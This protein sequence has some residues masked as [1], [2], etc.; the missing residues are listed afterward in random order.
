M[1]MKLTAFEQR[2]SDRLPSSW[3]AALVLVATL[4]A[5]S[6][7]AQPA[8]QFYAGKQ[9]K[10]IIGTSAGGG[11]DTNARLLARY[12][13][14]HIPG[15]PT[16]VPQNMPGAGGIRASSFLYSSAPQDG[17][18][19]G[20]VDSSNVVGPLFEK[21][22]EQFDPAK[23]K[24]VGSIG[25]E[26]SLCVSWHETPIK[27]TR[28]FLEKEF[29]VGGSGAGGQLEIYPKV[30]NAIIGTRMKIISGYAGGNDVVL[31]MERGEVQGRCGWSYSGIMSTRPTW[32][33]E[34]KLNF[35]IQLGGKAAELPEVPVVTDLVTSQEHKD[36]LNVI[37]A[38]RQV[39]RG[40]FAPPGISEAQLEVLR[41]A[42]MDTMRDPNFLA[43]AEKM[44][45]TPA[46]TTGAEVQAIVERL[47]Q[48]SPKVIDTAAK[49]LGK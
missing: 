5:P 35:L 26:P 43:D 41:K 18:V 8:E 24:W 27:T 32:V 19:I 37:F 46:P 42:F 10:L 29:I 2:S 33:N 36:V 30:L 23:V 34:K 48:S 3:V 25:P 47:Y 9:I 1:I 39:Q 15:N 44:A 20:I 16:I 4:A 31:A 45:L 11:Y 14:A 17:T 38:D 40:F 12:Y 13:G 28:D 6:A 21:V 49:I 7:L 22:R